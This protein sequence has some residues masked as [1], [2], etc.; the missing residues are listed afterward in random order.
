MTSTLNA[1]KSDRELLRG[2]SVVSSTHRPEVLCPALRGCL[3][4]GRGVALV[5][6]SIS[7]EDGEKRNGLERERLLP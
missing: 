4:I 6:S 2:G 5:T 1:E 3:S 7:G